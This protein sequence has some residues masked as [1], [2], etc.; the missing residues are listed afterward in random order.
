MSVIEDI[1][2]PSSLLR[3]RGERYTLKADDSDVC[4]IIRGDVSVSDSIG[5]ISISTGS[6]AMLLKIR[7]WS[8]APAE[9]TVSL[10]LTDGNVVDTCWAY[11][12]VT[13][14][15]TFELLLDIDQCD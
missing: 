5:I 15:D 11:N 10:L 1:A 6:I 3:V 9:F 12:D 8:V 13:F 2:K 14:L 7:H 4:V